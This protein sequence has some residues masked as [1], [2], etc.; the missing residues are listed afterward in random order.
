M[1]EEVLEYASATRVLIFCRDGLCMAQ[2]HQLDQEEAALR[3]E[4]DEGRISTARQR[5]INL[6]L[7]EIHRRY[8]A[9]FNCLQLFLDSSRAQSE[10]FPFFG[11]A[12]LR[13][14]D[15]FPLLWGTTAN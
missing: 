2:L 15:I 4:E 8:V 14:S 7:V 1:S 6:E 3:K 10:R 12:A 13:R 5:A 11:T 9:H